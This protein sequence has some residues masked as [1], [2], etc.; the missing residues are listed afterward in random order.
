MELT[1]T[2][3][4][5]D[6]SPGWFSYHVRIHG[7]IGKGDGWEWLRR[8]SYPVSRICASG[9][10]NQVL[11]GKHFNRAIRVHQH[12]LE[13]INRLILDV[14]LETCSTDVQA[15]PQGLEELKELAKEPSAEILSVV[16][17]MGVVSELNEQYVAFTE[18]L[19]GQ[20]G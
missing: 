7:C 14:S 1:V 12:M 5:G 2:V 18:S 15:R 8:D 10:I 9:S 13:A 4:K 3:R 16:E 6:Y 11:N 19:R 20:V 17:R